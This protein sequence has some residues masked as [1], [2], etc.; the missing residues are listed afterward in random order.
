MS[1]IK[2]QFQFL[3]TT[4]LEQDIEPCFF[5]GFPASNGHIAARRRTP[6][7]NGGGDSQVA[8]GPRCIYE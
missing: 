5:R 6:K 3:K 1:I 2:Y 7:E 4:H 8:A